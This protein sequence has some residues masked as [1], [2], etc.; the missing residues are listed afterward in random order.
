[1]LI[2]YILRI[3]NILVTY[4]MLFLHE[5]MIKLNSKMNQERVELE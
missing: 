4:D 2:L 5:I 1:M 3:I